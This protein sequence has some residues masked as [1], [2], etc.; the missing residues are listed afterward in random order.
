M[1]TYDY[2][3][4]KCNNIQEEFHGMKDEQEILCNECQSICKKK[5]ST[6]SS[7]VLKGSGWPSKEYKMKADMTRKNSRMKGIS[8][9][10]ELAGDAVKNIDDLKNKVN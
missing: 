1:P 3:C 5:F 4:T 10:R 2:E 9:E 8:N 6:G 7:F